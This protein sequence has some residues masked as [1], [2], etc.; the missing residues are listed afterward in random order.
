MQTPERWENYMGQGYKK[1]IP[2]NLG[3]VV[4]TSDLFS[5]NLHTAQCSNLYNVYQEFCSLLQS[6]LNNSFCREIW[7]ISDGTSDFLVAHPVLSCLRDHIKS[8]WSWSQF[9]YNLLE[10]DYFKGHTQHP[11]QPHKVF[12]QLLWVFWVGQTGSP[13][14]LYKHCFVSSHFIVITALEHNVCCWH[15]DF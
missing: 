12:H 11:W 4:N 7:K 5:F 6:C 1:V 2:D 14:N 13:Q 9:V 15:L 3:L 8:L 10:A